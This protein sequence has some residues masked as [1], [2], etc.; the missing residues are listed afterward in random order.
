MVPFALSMLEDLVFCVLRLDDDCLVLA[1]STLFQMLAIRLC[2][3]LILAAA[4]AAAL[5]PFRLEL[6]RDGGVVDDTRPETTRE[7]A[8]DLPAASRRLVFAL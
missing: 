1:S 6:L 3:W 2:A 5:L 8:G 7:A 4:A